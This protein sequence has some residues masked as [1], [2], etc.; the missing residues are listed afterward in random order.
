MKR[1]ISFFTVCFLSLFGEEKSFFVETNGAKLFCSVLGEGSPVIVLH[2]GPGL[3]QGYLRP[4]MDKLS[5]VCQVIYYDQRGGGNSQGDFSEE[6]INLAVAVEDLDAVRR[7]LGCKTVSIMGHSWGGLLAMLYAA[8]HPEAVDKLVLIDSMTASS[9]DFSPCVEEWGRR[10][11]PYLEELETIETSDAYLA[12]DPD[13]AVHF[14]NTI[15]GPYC[16]RMDHVKRLYFRASEETNRNWIRTYAI[17]RDTF[18]SKPFDFHD[19]LKRISCDTLI[20]HGDRDLILLSSAEQLQKS[21]P[22]SKLAVIEECG[23]FPFVE[24]PEEL[25]SILNAFLYFQ[26]PVDHRVDLGR[27]L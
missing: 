27:D 21:I 19:E 1:L 15:F 12:G 18:F 17:F 5:E 23:H 13:T 9:D 24:K 6:K 26:K 2:G 14:F 4:H 10:L 3:S 16:A 11:A 8:A 7:E 22:G 20:V 25:F